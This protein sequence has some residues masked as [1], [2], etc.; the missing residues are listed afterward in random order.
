MRHLLMQLVHKLTPRFL[1]P[2]VA[3]AIDGKYDRIQMTNWVVEVIAPDGSR[4]TYQ[5]SMNE[6]VSAMVLAE[7]FAED[8]RDEFPADSKL[9]L[10][11]ADEYIEELRASLQRVE[12]A[13]GSISRRVLPAGEET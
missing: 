2:E 11:P 3:D 8:W 9:F 5:F 13:F 10:Y 7:A 12:E 1:E 6:E 4:D